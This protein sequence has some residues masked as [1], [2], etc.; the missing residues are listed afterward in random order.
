MLHCLTADASLDAADVSW[1]E[2]G[3]LCGF[4]LREFRGLTALADIDPEGC[5]GSGAG[6]FGHVAQR[7]KSWTMSPVGRVFVT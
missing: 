4:K 7:A 1:V 6:R 5:E 2:V 3:F